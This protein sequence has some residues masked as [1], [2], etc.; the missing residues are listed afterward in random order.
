M[1]TSIA[2]QILECHRELKEPIQFR[3]L[4]LGVLQVSECT[5][6]L[7]LMSSSGSTCLSTRIK[8]AWLPPSVL[9]HCNCIAGRCTTCVAWR[10]MH[11]TFALGI[12]RS[13]VETCKAVDFEE[14]IK[15]E[16]HK[17]FA[18]CY[19]WLKRGNI[20]SPQAPLFLRFSVAQMFISWSG[21]CWL[22]QERTSYYQGQI[23]IH[24]K[25][26]EEKWNEKKNSYNKKRREN[27]AWHV[28]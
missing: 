4:F 16:L 15:R 17:I 8:P 12:S 27:W 28:A 10:C 22:L 9:L 19:S 18:R 14:K 5:P 6:T 20:H 24:M 21:C 13:A 11:P 26:M 1:S 3:G 23:N 25:L 2:S 7:Y